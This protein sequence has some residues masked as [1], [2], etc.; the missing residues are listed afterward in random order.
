MSAAGTH[1]EMWGDAETIYDSAI[2][3]CDKFVFAPGN[4]GDTIRDFEQ[5]RDHIELTGFQ[6]LEFAGLDIH[7]DGRG[8]S[9]IDFHDGNTII[10]RGVTSLTAD[11][12]FF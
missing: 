3:G 1:D 9:V 8:G 12:F 2:G 11:D 5:G 4:G 7:S 10:V 6:D